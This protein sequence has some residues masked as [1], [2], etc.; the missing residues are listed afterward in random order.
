MINGT[1]VIKSGTDFRNLSRL[2]LTWQKATQPQRDRS[3]TS[4]G[5]AVGKSVTLQGHRV[6]V[7]VECLEITG[8]YQEDP[9]MKVIVD[10]LCKDSEC[11]FKY[12]DKSP[13][14]FFVD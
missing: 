2:D 8:A 12:V 1:A 10:D 3:E 7:T 9:E 6:Q 11:L 13:P 4:F 5:S 14:S